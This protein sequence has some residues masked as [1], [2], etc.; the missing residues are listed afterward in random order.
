MTGVTK[1]AVPGR[2]GS[3]NEG[4]SGYRGPA[5]LHLTRTLRDSRSFT[6]QPAGSNSIEQL[7]LE[8]NWRTEIKF[9]IRLGETRTLLREKESGRVTVSVEVTGSKES[10]P[11]TMDEGYR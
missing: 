4:D 6:E 5:L 11:T 1:T 3:N 10:L 8:V 7:L 2:R 9:L